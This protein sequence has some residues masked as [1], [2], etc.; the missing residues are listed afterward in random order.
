MENEINYTNVGNRIRAER[1]CFGITREKFSELLQLS[2][3]YVGQI[4]RGERKM[5][6]DTLIN[7][8][9]CLHISL[10]FLVYGSPDMFDED[11]SLKSLI[12]KCSDKES[13]VI[14][15]VIKV[16]LPHIKR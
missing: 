14:E 2:P 15:D 1:E 10:D 7:V 13:K 11:S 4:E 3:Y 12:N 6:I 9:E 8:S 5:S 16:I